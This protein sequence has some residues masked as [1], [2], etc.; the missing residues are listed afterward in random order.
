MFHL[1][2]VLLKLPSH[3]L[4][5]PSEL[6]MLIS[7]AVLATDLI[8][9]EPTTNRQRAGPRLHMGLYGWVKVDI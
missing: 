2:K 8:N 7:A 4:Y 5:R 1:D 6:G 3:N 9:L